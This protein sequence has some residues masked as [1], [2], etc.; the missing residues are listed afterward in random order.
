MQ[1]VNAAIL[2]ER[3]DFCSENTRLKD[4]LDQMKEQNLRQAELLAQLFDRIAEADKKLLAKSS[5]A[6]P[7]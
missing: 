6:D 4:E 3:E 1:K 5:V 2:K 7:R